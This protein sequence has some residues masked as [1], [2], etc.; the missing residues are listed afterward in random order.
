MDKAQGFETTEYSQEEVVSEKISAIAQI[1]QDYVREIPTCG[2]RVVQEGNLVKVIYTSFEPFLPERIRDA[3]DRAD[4]Y[5]KEMVKHLKK[6]FKSRQK[7]TL[8]L[9]ELKDRSDY[10]VQK[11]SMNERYT[12][13]AWKYFEVG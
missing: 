6:E 10:S 9:K 1:A 8:D 12:Y 13:S 4:S 5:I 3:Q 2:C 11:V 7:E